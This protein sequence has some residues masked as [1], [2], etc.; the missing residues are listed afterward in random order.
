MKL[1]PLGNRNTRAF[2]TVDRGADNSARL[3]DEIITPKVRN[4]R[5]K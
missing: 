3:R 5:F 2:A 4:R 1:E